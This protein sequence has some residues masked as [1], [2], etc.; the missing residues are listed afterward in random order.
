[1]GSI[2][3]KIQKVKAS[4]NPDIDNMKKRIRM[5]VDM[6]IEALNTKIEILNKC[7]TD[8]NSTTDMGQLMRVYQDLVEMIQSDKKG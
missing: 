4:N 1:M 7:K 8:A 2:S 5:L 3:K 6:Q